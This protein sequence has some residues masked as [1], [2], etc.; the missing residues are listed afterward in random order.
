VVLKQGRGEVKK[1]GG[2]G[3][4]GG[5]SSN[6][7]VLSLCGAGRRVEAGL[8]IAVR[9]DDEEDRYYQEMRV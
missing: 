9:G 8:K 1:G 5:I 4:G 3:G 2:L 6:G 7:K